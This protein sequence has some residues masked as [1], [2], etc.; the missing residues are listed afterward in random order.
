MCQNCIV[1][2]D[3]AVGV[4]KLTHHQRYILAIILCVL[5]GIQMFIGLGITVNSIYVYVAVAPGLYSERAEIGFVFLVMAVFGTHIIL[6]YLGGMKICE[7]CYLRAMKYL[8]RNS[9]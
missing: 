9:P 5:N 8:Y 7:R 6:V 4:F 1:F 2:D 3:M